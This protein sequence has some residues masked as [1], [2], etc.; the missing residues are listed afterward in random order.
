LTSIT[1]P[2]WFFVFGFLGGVKGGWLVSWAGCMHRER[3]ERAGLAFGSCSRLMLGIA[4]TRTSERS[5]YS[6]LYKSPGIIIS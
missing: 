5:Q 3:M 4:G 6:T 1:V 2:I